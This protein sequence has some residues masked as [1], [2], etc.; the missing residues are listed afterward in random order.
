[1]SEGRTFELTNQTK[2]TTTTLDG[3]ALSIDPNKLYLIDFSK[4]NSV[5]DLVLI[6]AAMSIAFPGDHPHIKALKPFLNTANPLDI[7]TRMPEQPKQVEL[8]LPKMKPINAG[9]DD[10]V[11]NVK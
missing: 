1:M 3:K 5:N 6:L 2:A 4:L 8:K 11:A 10:Y 9:S 7:P